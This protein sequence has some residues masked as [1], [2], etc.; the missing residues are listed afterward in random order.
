MV[1]RRGFVGCSI[2][3][4][5][6]PAVGRASSWRPGDR[7]GGIV[8]VHAHV[9]IKDY[10]E[11]AAV[12]GLRP[13]RFGPPP[14]GR[15]QPPSPARDD[16]AATALRLQLMDAAGVRMQVLSPTLAPYFADEAAA[17]LATQLQNDGQARLARAHPQRFASFASLPLP[18]V[19]A[20]LQEMR[21]AFDQLGAAGV[22]MQC[23]CLGLS[24]ADDRFDPLFA[25][26]NRRRAVLFLHPAVNGLAS[27]FL[28]DWSLTAAA[29]PTFEDSVIAMHLMIKGIPIRYPDIRIIIPNLGGGLSGLLER[30]DNQLP[31]FTPGFQGKPSEMARSF[32]YDTVSHGSR[33]ALRAAVDAFGADRLVP[34][35]DFPVLLSFEAYADTFGYVG[36]AGLARRDARAILYENAPRLLNL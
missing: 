25:E 12:S 22:T 26:M 30:L 23:F 4:M 32:W 5:F 29:G 1:N 9:Q 36:Q 34:G 13:P 2:C 35:S 11:F 6:A 19:D 27:P 15:P 8:D 16:E 10:L 3:A 7:T 20:S 24:I 21:R 18:H 17:I 14:S 31:Q 33:P 28:T